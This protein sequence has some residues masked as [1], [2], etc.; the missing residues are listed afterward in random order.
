MVRLI[1][2]NT[3]NVITDMISTNDTADGVAF[4]PVSTTPIIYTGA[5]QTAQN[6]SKKGDIFV[7]DAGGVFIAKGTTGSTDWIPSITP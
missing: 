5:D 2:N 3:S 4:A 6:P 7:T 1:D